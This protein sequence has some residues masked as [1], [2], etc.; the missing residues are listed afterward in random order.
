MKPI[1]YFILVLLITIIGCKKNT[2]AKDT[3]KT[4]QTVTITDTLPLTLNNNSKWLV[5]LE[6][7][8]GVKRMDSIVKQFDAR[9]TKNY[10]E[11]GNSLSNQT[12][13][14]IKNCTMTGKS[15]DQLHVVLVPMLDQIS[16]LKTATSSEA[17]EAHENLKALIQA[18]F[19]HFNL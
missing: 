11:L 7:D 15:H 8:I 16:I 4:N 14:I 9:E 6:T 19:K 10:M 1:L 12:N 18:Y 3:V 2:K 13:Y 17:S 5:N